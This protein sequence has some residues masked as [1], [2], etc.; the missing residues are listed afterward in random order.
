M[1]SELKNEKKSLVLALILG[2]SINALWCWLSL[3]GYGFSIF[4]VI[5]LVLSAQMLYQDYLN[6]PIAED[7]PLVGL[8]CFFLGAFGHS[9]FARA[10]YP[11]GGSN[12]FS[13]LVT[14][15]LMLWVAYRMGKSS[16]VEETEVSEH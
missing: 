14:M 6:S 1:S 11:D 10:A 13:I 16:Q 15:G 7:M 2:M 5:A 12:F 4:V 8:A 3:P 9:A